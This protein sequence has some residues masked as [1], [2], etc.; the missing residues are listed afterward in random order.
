MGSFNAFHW[1]IV[2]VIV[3]ILVAIFRGG[4]GG[5]SAPVICKR[6]G[7]NGAGKTMTRGSL[8]LEIVLWLCFLVPGIIYSIWRLTSRYTGCPKC[9]ANEMIPVDSPLG[10]KLLAEVAKSPEMKA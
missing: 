4:F 3:V 6:C 8:A 2:A 9:G 10:A 5:S 1:M 7:Y